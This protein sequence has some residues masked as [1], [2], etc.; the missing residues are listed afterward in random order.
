MVLEDD[1]YS[2]GTHLLGKP[3]VTQPDLEWPSFRVIW[4]ECTGYEQDDLFYN[5][6]ERWRFTALDAALG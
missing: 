3:D 2:C 1:F 5:P 6:Y 4:E